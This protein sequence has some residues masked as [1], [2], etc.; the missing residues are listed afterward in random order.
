VL[1]AAKKYISSSGESRDKLP[2]RKRQKTQ[3]AGLRTPPSAPRPSKTA[4]QAG[5]KMPCA[6]TLH[7]IFLPSG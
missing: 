5:D 1:F 3:V 7:G 6:M 4:F 2:I